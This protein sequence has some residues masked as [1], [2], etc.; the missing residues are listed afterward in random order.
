MSSGS[1]VWRVL[2]LP[3]PAQ[4]SVQTPKILFEA[5]RR[6]V[7]VAAEAIPSAVRRSAAKRFLVGVAVAA[8]VWAADIPVGSGQGRRNL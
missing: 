4:K 3:S 8:M 1:K 5:F 7:V 2:G 6:L